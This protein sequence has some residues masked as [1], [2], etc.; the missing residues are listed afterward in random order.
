MNDDWRLR[1]T[2]EDDDTAE[3]LT[4]RL[5]DH[6]THDDHTPVLHDRIVISSDGPEVFCYAGSREQAEATQCA[7]EQLAQDARWAA[8]QY[9]L[10]HWHPTAERWEDAERPLPETDAERTEELRQ[11]IAQERIDAER[12]GYPDFEVR[13][14]CPSRGAAIELAERLRDE[15]MPVVH[16]WSAVLIGAADEATAAQLAERLRAEAPA[17]S[18]V[19]VEGNMRAIY[20]ERPWRPYSVLG[21]MGG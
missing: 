12:Q 4:A 17:G 20:E 18:Q 9:E 7:V 5:K 21:G 13:V 19:T 14:Q 11:R 1:I 2:L 8:P 3:A 10:M 6:T 16:R 15:G